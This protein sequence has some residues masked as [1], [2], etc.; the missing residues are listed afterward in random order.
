MNILAYGSYN[1]GFRPESFLPSAR[2]PSGTALRPF[3]YHITRI[4]Y[5]GA[6]RLLYGY[7]KDFGESILTLAKI[8]NNIDDEF[9]PGQVHDFSVAE[10]DLR[11]F[12]H[13]TGKSI[14]PSEVAS[15]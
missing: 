14:K 12:S 8:P 6:D 4:E 3:P 1:L 11:Y 2:F 15:S 13:D 5:L 7:I 10:E 9:F